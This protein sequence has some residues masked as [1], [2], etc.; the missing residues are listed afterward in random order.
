MAF[1]SLSMLF[2]LLSDY[3]EDQS[4]VKDLL[5]TLLTLLSISVLPYLFC[6]SLG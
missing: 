2:L 3:Y 4:G 6:K 1:W 5:Q